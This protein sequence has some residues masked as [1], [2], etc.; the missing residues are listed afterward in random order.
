MRELAD[1]PGASA[2]R[3]PPFLWQALSMSGEE[4]VMG[5]GTSIAR[6]SSDGAGGFVAEER[7][8]AR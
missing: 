8:D 2:V 5:F 6:V 3:S 1:A 7:A 4:V